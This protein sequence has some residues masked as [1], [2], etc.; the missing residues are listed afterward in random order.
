[1]S[2]FNTELENLVYWSKRAS[3]V[4]FIK[5]ENKAVEH[6]LREVKK[7]RLLRDAR[8]DE[9]NLKALC[10]SDQ[11]IARRFEQ[12]LNSDNAVTTDAADIER[13]LYLLKEMS[14]MSGDTALCRLVDQ[15]MERY[16][17]TQSRLQELTE[18]WHQN[19][20]TMLA[21]ESPTKSPAEQKESIDHEIEHF[22]QRNQQ[23]EEELVRRRRRLA[24]LR[25][26]KVE[27]QTIHQKLKA[28]QQ[29]HMRHTE[30][31]FELAQLRRDIKEKKKI[32]E[33]L[34]ANGV[35]ALE[36]LQ[37][38]ALASLK[39]SEGDPLDASDLLQTLVHLQRKPTT[40]STFH[41]SHVYRPWLM[42]VVEGNQA[43]QELN[44]LY[45]RLFPQSN[46]TAIQYTQEQ[47]VKARILLKLMDDGDIPLTDL[48]RFIES[49]A[50]EHGYDPK[51]ASRSIHKL[52]GH[53]LVMIEHTETD[54]IVRLLL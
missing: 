32:L 3:S 28:L 49:F 36:R 33:T 21:N 52:V 41:L 11:T 19:Q 38:Q 39:A 18:Q 23:L 37:Q 10:A 27:H 2:S 24:D 30:R 29:E 6:D 20:Q 9:Y 26:S 51:E 42:C 22:R 54:S 50:M 17:T 8:P 13:R 34:E 15:H 46:P 14:E 16:V 1:M 35:S 40:P 5:S 48:T 4:K 53:Q 31:D 47:Q 25:K 43:P 45:H 44:P 12:E 7:R